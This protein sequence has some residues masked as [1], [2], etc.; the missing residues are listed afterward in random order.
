VHT[1]TEHA[2][3]VVETVTAAGEQARRLLFGDSVVRFPLDVS[4]VECYAAAK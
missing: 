4:T 1:P 2:S 3:R